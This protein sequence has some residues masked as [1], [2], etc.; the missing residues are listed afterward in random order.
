[1]IVE[2]QES[3]GEVAC[4]IDPS[5]FKCS[6]PMLEIEWWQVW[7]W[8]WP[9]MACKK[10]GWC[11][12]LPTPSVVA[13]LRAKGSPACPLKMGQSTSASRSK[14]ASALP[15]SPAHTF[16]LKSRPCQISCQL[17]PFL[18][19]LPLKLHPRPYF[20]C[21]AG[22]SHSLQLPFCPFILTSNSNL[23]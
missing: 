14:A 16:D 8:W 6:A 1:M 7:H 13:P 10:A 4:F 17:L 19:P 21:I 11:P 5:K 2:E 3:A 18:P 22:P 23:L 20:I 12:G 9:P 15:P